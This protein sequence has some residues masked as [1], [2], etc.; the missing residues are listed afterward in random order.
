MSG[1][2]SKGS[3]SARAREGP[4]LI[5]TE[6]RVFPHTFD[7]MHNRKEMSRVLRKESAAHFF[8]H[9]WGVCVPI[10]AGLTCN[11]R[12]PPTAAVADCAKR[13]AAQ[14]RVEREPHG[15]ATPS[16][17]I[18]DCFLLVTRPHPLFHAEET[19]HSQSQSLRTANALLSRAALRTPAST[20]STAKSSRVG[21]V[22]FL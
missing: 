19:F 5:G 15:R 10:E 8:V 17:W 18:S 11:L 7:C 9:F 3:P 12:P 21:L 14:Q 2:S 4:D 20:A 6:E 22:V 13:I 1:Y 16:R